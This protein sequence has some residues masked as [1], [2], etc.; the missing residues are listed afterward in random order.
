MSAFISALVAGFGLADMDGMVVP[1]ARE[2]EPL[3]PK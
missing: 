2:P 3:S 1:L